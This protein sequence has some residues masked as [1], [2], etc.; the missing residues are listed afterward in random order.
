MIQSIKNL[1]KAPYNKK[2]VIFG[3]LRLFQWK[4]IKFFRL[5]DFK[6]SLWHDRRIFLNYDS[7]Q[8]MWIMYNYMVDW[9]E[10]SLIKCYLKK[11]SVVADVGTN[12]GFYTIWMSKFVKAGGHIHCFE[13]DAT[14]F[15]RL[16]KNC[17]LNNLENVVLNNIALSDSDGVVSFTK[18]LDGENHIAI[19]NVE[20]TVSIPTRTFDSY[21]TINR[22]AHLDYIKVDIE[23]FELFF[24]R[25]AQE[26]LQRKA[27]DIIQLEINNRVTNSNTTVN[28]LLEAIK[29]HDYSLCRFN[30]DQR[31]LEQVDFSVSRENYFAVANLEKANLRLISL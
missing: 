13:P 2:H 14:N 16:K 17:G 22:I 9:E 18:S 11:K 15:E 23:G 6:Y 1:Y 30:T 21:C 31:Q 19:S 10:F 7:F 12:M 28:D 27:V 24:L 8:S 29:Q 26:L 25:G 5:K 20:N 3:L 4:F